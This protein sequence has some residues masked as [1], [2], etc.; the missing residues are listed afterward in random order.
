MTGKTKQFLANNKKYE[1]IFK[2]LYYH[3]EILKI[4]LRYDREQYHELSIYYHLL[5]NNHF[6]EFLYNIIKY[7][8]DFLCRLDMGILMVL[9]N[10]LLN[11]QSIRRE[12][13]EIQE[14]GYNNLQISYMF[15]ETAINF[16][17][18]FNEPIDDQARYYN[19]DLDDDLNEEITELQARYS[20]IEEGKSM[21]LEILKSIKSGSALEYDYDTTNFYALAC[22]NDFINLIEEIFD[23]KQLELSLI[24]EAKEIIASSIEIKTFF[25]K[26]VKYQQKLIGEERVKSFDLKRAGNLLTKL[27]LFEQRHVVKP[28][29]TYLMLIKPDYTSQKLD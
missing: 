2:K 6:L 14:D 13:F 28:K 4:F 1:F 7:D 25:G 8:E 12:Y 10:I 9:E 5:L 22:N 11:N 27:I 16:Q 18:I 23:K 20:A 29:P 26:G 19:L 24:E 21:L 17:Q 15:L 3:P